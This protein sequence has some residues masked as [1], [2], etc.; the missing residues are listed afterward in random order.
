[1]LL[2]YNA[3]VDELDADTRTRWTTI[4]ELA[5]QIPHA[6]NPTA[7]PEHYVPPEHWTRH[8]AVQGKEPKRHKSHRSGRQLPVPPLHFGT[9]KP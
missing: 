5:S 9:L 3:H 7:I 4:H 1:M 2:G 6:W 8:D